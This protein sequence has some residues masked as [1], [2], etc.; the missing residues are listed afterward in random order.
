MTSYVEHIHTYIHTNVSKKVKSV[1][2]FPTRITGCR[3]PFVSNC[4][5]W[6][7]WN[8]EWGLIVCIERIFRILERIRK[9]KSFKVQCQEFL[10]IFM[11]MF[12]L[13]G[14]YI[15][16]MKF[17][18]TRGYTH[19]VFQ[20]ILSAPTCPMNALC[21]QYIIDHCFLSY[22]LVKNFKRKMSLLIF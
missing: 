1:L 10:I 11:F 5:S 7:T 8:K 12:A 22:F 21:R 9:Q 15:F 3:R 20:L 16:H 14:E 6:H 19:T 17:K 4:W 2:Q 13:I 18:Y